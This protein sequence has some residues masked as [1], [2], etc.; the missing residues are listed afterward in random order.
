MSK[1]RNKQKIFQNLKVISDIRE[2]KTYFEYEWKLPISYYNPYSLLLHIV[3]TKV[4]ENMQSVTTAKILKSKCGTLIIQFGDVNPIF[5]LYAP[6]SEKHAFSV[7]EELA[8]VS[9]KGVYVHAPNFTPVQSKFHL[10]SE[11]E[12]ILVDCA[13]LIKTIDS[14]LNSGTTTL[15]NKRARSTFRKN[16]E[17]NVYRSANQ[18]DADNIKTLLSNWAFAAHSKNKKYNLAKDYYSIQWAL[19]PPNEDIHSFIGFRG[20]APSA[21]SLLTT[22]PSYPFMATQLIAKSL[23]YSFVSG[24]YNSTSTWELYCCAQ[25]LIKKGIRFINL[26]DAGLNGLKEY[27]S[28]FG[29]NLRQSSWQFQQE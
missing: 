28:R 4:R 29:K 6:K 14:D 18:L 8:Y 22:L 5:H 16:L 1:P 12:Q 27:K 24:G 20:A 26:S 19:N 2:I 11:R 21:Y 7:C 9:S 25:N 13:Y 17:S 10:I 23:N 15:L 3:K